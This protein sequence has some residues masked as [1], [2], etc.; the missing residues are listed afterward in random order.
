MRSNRFGRTAR[1]V[2]A[3]GALVACCGLAHGADGA[4]IAGAG[5]IDAGGAIGDGGIADRLARGAA[6]IDSVRN[7]LAL[8]EGDERDMLNAYLERGPIAFNA[9]AGDREFTGELL[10][11]VHEHAKGPALARLAPGT[12][13][14][15]A[16]QTAVVTL[17]EGVGEGELAVMLEAL[18][19][20]AIV[21]P[22]WLVFPAL[23][24]NDSQYG[25]SW[26]HTRIQSAAAW[27]ITTGSGDVI[28]AVCDSGVDIDH[29][30]LV[31]LLVPGYNTAQNLPQVDGGGVD[32]LNGHGT[33]V[34][35]CAAAEGNN[36]IGVVGVGW[37]FRIMPIRVSEAPDG[38]AAISEI[39]EGALWAAE[40]GARIVNAS[41]SGATDGTISAT[42]VRMLGEDSLLFWAAGNSSA[43]TEGGSDNYVI[44]ASTRS[45]DAISGFSNFGP[46]VDVAAPGSGVRATRRGGSYGNS[47]GTSFA[48]PIAAG[49]GGMIV[50]QN[51]ALLAEDVRDVLTES[52]DDLGAPGRDDFYGHGRVN[53]F[54]AVQLAPAFP[55]RSVAPFMLDFESGSIDPVFW[56]VS[57][58]ASVV[59]DTASGDG[60]LA[61]RL[62]QG[63]S[64]ETN[65][66]TGNRILGAI[67]VLELD[68]RGT[69][70]EGGET[71]DV[72]FRDIDGG[73]N[74]LGSIEPGSSYE[75][76]VLVA[77]LTFGNS[78]LA[79][80]VSTQLDD[81]DDA[82]FVDNIAA[83]IYTAATL[84][85][86]DDFSSGG[87]SQ[88][89][90]ESF[91]DAEIVDDGGDEAM[92]VRN[93]TT[94]E[95]FTIDFVGDTAQL[96]TVRMN[97][98][99][100]QLTGD[101]TLRV[102]ALNVNNDWQDIFVL[103]ATD[104]GVETEA[105]FEAQLPILA[106]RADGRLRFIASGAQV[107]GGWI[108]DDIFIGIPQEPE[109][110]ADLTGEGDL[111]IF[112][113][114]EFLAR[115]GAQDAST[116]LSPD[117]A[118]NI[119][120]VLAYLAIFDEGC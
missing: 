105:A 27:D 14:V 21:E 2:I 24:P 46:A 72:E 12:R 90:W 91:I 60:S 4:T 44:V 25:S 20:Y 104:A 82:V 120:D 47:S 1:G 65:T 8:R 93:G 50:S 3:A 81:G 76:E 85:F 55:T 108:V 7:V 116:D 29:P 83:T 59:A 88:L 80:R 77:P 73:W 96:P 101:E 10:V 79:I 112:D 54:N 57:T 87:F 19:E 110:E 36:S 75:R 117:G 39:L 35:G 45:N 26:Q 115:F 41:Y 16:G 94:P 86:A 100:D 118:F 22:N 102:Q 6:V 48:S 15:L 51:P 106:F 49:V 67:R 99:G 113:V 34:A 56:P 9:V 68:V 31:N 11:T 89:L 28:I 74:P 5:S 92:R 119:F 111:N 70:L 63:A 38:S 62:G 103:N 40:N 58:S 13:Q 17:P 69:G 32:D 95:S 61:L 43:F 71:L 53:T 107:G 64:L 18:G 23:V 33:F 42:A 97:I 37:N 98:R 109:C 78:N 52:A 84:P 30:D 114:L 66:L